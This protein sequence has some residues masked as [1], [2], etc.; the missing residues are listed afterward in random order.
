MDGSGKQYLR[1]KGQCVPRPQGG[2]GSE[3]VVLRRQQG[4]AFGWN[5]VAVGRTE[6]GN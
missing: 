4:G 6:A 3:C 5:G 1:Q 2:D